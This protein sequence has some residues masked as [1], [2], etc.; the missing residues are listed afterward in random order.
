MNIEQ[1]LEAADCGKKEGLMGMYPMAAQGLA[2]ELR[3]MREK[4]DSDRRDRCSICHGTGKVSDG[5]EDFQCQ[6]C[7]P[8]Y[9]V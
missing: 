8:E 2:E 7:K 4:S 6:H 9:D 1:A 3:M 5:Y